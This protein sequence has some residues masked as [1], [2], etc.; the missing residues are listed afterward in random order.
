MDLA[1][2]ALFAF[3]IFV[4]LIFSR[5]MNRAA[6]VERVLA[7]HSVE[8]PGDIRWTAR[9]VGLKM[10]YGAASIVALIVVSYFGSRSPNAKG[11]VTVSTSTIVASLVAAAVAG[12]LIGFCVA[13]RDFVSERIVHGLRVHPVL[14]AY[15]S[16]GLG[17]LL[18][19]VVTGFVAAIGG[20][21]V[22]GSLLMPRTGPSR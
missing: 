14:R 13:L 9:S 17:S 11:R 2:L 8:P 15:Y 4:V 19:W 16:W 10:A 21:I 6:A 7:G 3:V 18:L 5:W 20:I 22:Y 1:L 12:A